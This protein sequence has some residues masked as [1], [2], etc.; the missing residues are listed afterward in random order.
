MDD[1]TSYSIIGL[2]SNNEL[3]TSV[4]SMTRL[5]DLTR[6]FNMIIELLERIN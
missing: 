2:V 4:H 3:V 6:W 5:Y 1:E